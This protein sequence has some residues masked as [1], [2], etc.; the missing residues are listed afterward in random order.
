MVGLKNLLFDK[1]LSDLGL[2]NLEQ[3]WPWRDLPADP[4]TMGK[5]LRRHSQ[6]LQ[7][8]ANWKDETQEV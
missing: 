6:A 3:S 8:N 4:S 5:S 7:N 2:F 1:S